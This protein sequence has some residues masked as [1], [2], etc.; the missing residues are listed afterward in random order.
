MFT[1]CNYLSE[2][3]SRAIA[4]IDG[5]NLFYAVRDAFGY[6]FPNYDPLKLA[7]EVC[8]GQQ[9]RLDQVRFYTGVPAGEDSP[10]WHAFWRAKLVQMGRLGVWTYSRQLQYRKKYLLQ[11]GVKHTYR[12][13]YEKGIDVRIAIDVISLAVA[14]RFDVALIFS[15]DQDLSE[16]ADEVLKIS[17]AEN[18]QLKIASAFPASSNHRG[19]NKTVWIKIDRATYDRCID[20]RD[21]R[22]PRPR[23]SPRRP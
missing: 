8:N 1:A 3:R 12:T 2:H 7:Q 14:H 22:L 17:K 15:Q 5:Q 20:P 11:N 6:T 21:Y 9:W 10:S 13:G 19:I 16:V 18:R 23:R 4:F